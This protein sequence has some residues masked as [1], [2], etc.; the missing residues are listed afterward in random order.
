MTGQLNYTTLS[1]TFGVS[2]KTIKEY[3]NYFEDV[4]L[5]KRIDKFHT[6]PKERIKSSKKIYVLDNGFIQIAPKNSKN[7][8]NSLENWVFTVLN[9]KDDALTYLKE[10]KEIDFYSENRLYQVTY[11]MENEKTRKREIEA[12]E[13]FSS[14]SRDYCLITFDAKEEIEGIV[15]GTIDSFIFEE[16]YGV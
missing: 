11:V 10:N 4:F 8:G 13:S 5:L 16:K 9:K 7:L 1:N 15:V 14:L 2:D 3:I 6:K 12:F